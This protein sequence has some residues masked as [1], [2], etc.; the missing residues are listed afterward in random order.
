[1]IEIQATPYEWE[2]VFRNGD[3]IDFHKWSVV[4]NLHAL[5]R[6]SRR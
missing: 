6:I 5:R 4:N 3:C 2:Q 1:M